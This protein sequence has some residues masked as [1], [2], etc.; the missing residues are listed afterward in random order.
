MNNDK[1]SVLYILA[2]E[3]DVRFPAVLHPNADENLPALTV[4]HQDDN[5]IVVSTKAG[6]V[7]LN[8][9]DTLRYD[10]HSGQVIRILGPSGHTNQFRRILAATKLPQSMLTTDFPV[11]GV[12]K[13]GDYE[14]NFGVSSFA[15]ERRREDGYYEVNLIAHINGRGPWYRFI[16]RKGAERDE[17]NLMWFCDMLKNVARRQSGVFS[18]YLDKIELNDRVARDREAHR[19]RQIIAEETARIDAENERRRLEQLERSQRLEEIRAKSFAERMADILA[20]GQKTW[21]VGKKTYFIHQGSLYHTMVSKKTKVEWETAFEQN[22]LQKMVWQ[23]STEV[24]REL[25]LEEAKLYLS[26][27]KPDSIYDGSGNEEI[28]W[29]KDGREVAYGV[30]SADRFSVLIEAFSCFGESTFEGDDAN[31]LRHLGISPA[32]FATA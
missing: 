16:I 21:K 7:T 22:L 15:C 3:F 10:K 24:K 1:G 9:D 19:A 17:S 2:S 25:T 4:A 8:S 31:S 32:R 12:I 26:S 27:L 14:N 18:S 30:F 23:I 29:L 20:S 13:C 6:H 11:D 28:G 5:K